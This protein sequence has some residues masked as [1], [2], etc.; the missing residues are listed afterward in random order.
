[1]RNILQ[2]E[3]YVE[4]PPMLY[5]DPFFR[6]T[7]LIKEEI[8]KFKW[9]EGEKG[10]KLTWEQACQEWTGTY[11]EKFERYLMDTLHVGTAVGGTPF[12]ES[13]PPDDAGHQR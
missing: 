2:T 10:R 11:R 4:V 5:T 8:R 12:P 6:I 7:M 13:V 3:Q 9:T 1:M